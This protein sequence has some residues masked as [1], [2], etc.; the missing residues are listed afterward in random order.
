MVGC[1]TETPDYELCVQQLSVDHADS[2]VE[3]AYNQ[4]K[5]GGVESIP[6]LIRNL[7]STS[8]ANATYFQ[9]EEVFMRADGTYQ[10]SH[11]TIGDACEAILR[12]MLDFECSN[13]LT[14]YYSVIQAAT[15]ADWLQ[16]RSNQSLESLQKECRREMLKNIR[17]DI[18][19]ETSTERIAILNQ[20][21]SHIQNCGRD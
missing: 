18:E 10:M 16:S 5:L 13:K 17:A 11:P 4:L 8:A 14:S 3:K 12:Q 2:V 19:I 21:Y 7:Q 20:Q 9:R 1:S 15:F 6:A